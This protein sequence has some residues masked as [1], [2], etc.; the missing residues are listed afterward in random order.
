MDQALA[1]TTGSIVEDAV[2]AC[3]DAQSMQVEL[4]VN[5]PG[6][7]PPTLARVHSVCHAV[8]D[9]CSKQSRNTSDAAAPTDLNAMRLAEGTQCTPDGEDGACCSAEDGK[10]K[11]PGSKGVQNPGCWF[12]GGDLEPGLSIHPCKGE[13]RS[14]REWCSQINT[15][16]NYYWYIIL[17]SLIKNET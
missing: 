2:L 6:P 8:G 16:C 4:N 17:Q 9:A 15:L 11:F 7:N 13:L 12:G 10:F 1:S 14:Y 3:S 5:T